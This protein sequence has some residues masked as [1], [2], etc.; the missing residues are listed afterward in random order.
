M[1]G[2]NARKSAEQEPELFKADIPVMGEVVLNKLKSE[3]LVPALMSCHEELGAIQVT[4]IYDRLRY[5]VA[6]R[7]LRRAQHEYA[8]ASFIA[9]GDINVG[10]V[11]TSDELELVNTANALIYGALR[12]LGSPTMSGKELA[13]K[14]LITLYPVDAAPPY[15]IR[16][17]A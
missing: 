16:F 14:S 8:A 13:Q 11:I 4:T 17:T 10:R 6:E 2:F 12:P 7:K 9:N 5:A 15:E 3:K 1:R